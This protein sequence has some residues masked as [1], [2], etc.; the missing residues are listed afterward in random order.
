MPGHTRPGR[1]VVSNP[2]SSPSSS[3]RPTSIPAVLAADLDQ[4]DVEG[5]LAAT[6]CTA[7]TSP[8]PSLWTQSRPHV[9]DDPP[10][11]SEGTQERVAHPDRHPV[12]PPVLSQERPHQADENGQ[13]QGCGEPRTKALGRGPDQHVQ[14]H[15]HDR[16]SFQG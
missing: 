15:F 3:S 1:G 16:I 14:P 8:T 4:G 7:L 5:A 11:E 2:G 12:T 10:R 9:A 13:E 6:V